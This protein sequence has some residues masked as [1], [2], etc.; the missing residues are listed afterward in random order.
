[1]S[2]IQAAGVR[3][4]PRARDA[5]L[6]DLFGPS[7]KIGAALGTPTAESLGAAERD[8]L[9][10][11]F[12]SVTAENV[13]KPEPIHP[14]ED[15]FDFEP[16]DSFVRAFG[17]EGRGMQV[18]GHCLVWHQQCPGWFFEQDGRPVSRQ[19][20]RERL[21]RH[22]RT[23]VERYRGRIAGWDVVN[24]AIGDNGEGLRRTP[25]L[26]HLGPD[27]LLEAFN[28]AN[29]A[30]PEVEL[31][32]NDFNLER[33]DKCRHAVAMLRRLLDSGA[34]VDAVGIQGHWILDQVPFAELEEAI[35]RFA[36]LGLK[37]AITE[38]DLDVVER[39]DCGADTS[40][41]RR[42]RVAEDVYRDGCPAEVLERQAEQYGRLFDLLRR[43]P[44]VVN[45]VTFWGLHDGVSWLNY[46]PG[47]RTNHPLLFDRQC[48]PK[49]AF[50]RVVR[51]AAPAAP[52]EPRVVVKA[53]SV[54]P[55]RAEP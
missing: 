35:D 39:P 12:N 55:V 19:R 5:R 38:L 40:V 25:W 51:S 2:T 3:S 52:A 11:H 15:R 50:A 1:M 13:M 8:L 32:Y 44:D 36:G 20:L 31:Y 42:Y 9:D 45:R 34:R 49:P 48:R 28:T 6:H 54:K 29:E 18:I 46:W 17:P 14:E 27:Y 30:D 23:V 37:V 21:R 16:A 47:E 22:V 41:H 43:Y 53:R 24:E 26:E 4:E 10:R 33:R 7:M